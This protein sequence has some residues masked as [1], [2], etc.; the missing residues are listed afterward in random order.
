MS[1]NAFEGARRVALIFAGLILI[2]GIAIIWEQNPSPDLYYRVNSFDG[3]AVRSEQCDTSD[4]T[5]YANYA[6]PAGH[7]FSVRFCFAAAEANDGT[8]LIPAKIG[9]TGLML[10]RPYST[11]VLEYTE[12]YS[13]RALGPNAPAFAEAEA[14]YQEQLW[15]MKFEAIG[16]LIGCLV[17][18]WIFVLLV[19]WIVRGFASIPMGQDKKYSPPMVARGERIR[20][21]PERDRWVAK[22]D[23][24]DEPGEA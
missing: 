23:A 6:T 15:P 19:G 12:Q 4:A 18:F 9:P 5:K 22:G 21:H 3:A 11:E 8:W 10:Y 20:R 17:G 2:A 7:S 13:K 16:V 24:V 1:I 14:I